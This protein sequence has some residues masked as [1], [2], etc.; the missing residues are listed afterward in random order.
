MPYSKSLLYD[1]EHQDPSAVRSSHLGSVSMLVFRLAVLKTPK[2]PHNGS[3]LSFVATMNGWRPD[4]FS[5]HHGSLSFRAPR[6]VRFCTLGLR[7]VYLES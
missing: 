5:T 1:D 3:A 7:S 6:N 2:T 4:L